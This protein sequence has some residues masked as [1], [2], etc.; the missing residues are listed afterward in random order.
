MTEDLLAEIT[1]IRSV[2]TRLD[3]RIAALETNPQTD[4]TRPPKPPENADPTKLDPNSPTPPTRPAANFTPPTRQEWTLPAPT[5]TPLPSQ[6]APQLTSLAIAKDPRQHPA[7]A[8]LPR[9]REVELRIG[10]IW[11]V[12]IGI[13]VLL[14]GLVFLGNHVYHEFISTLGAAGKLTLVSLAAGLMAGLGHLARRRRSLA[15][16]GRVLTGGAIATG[17]Y[18]AYAAHFVEPLRV[19]ASP[20]IGGSLLLAA[21]GGILWLADRLRSQATAALTISL[22]FYTGA[23]NP[24]T[25]FSLAA[26]VLLAV[27]GVVLL[28][29][30]HWT[31]LSLVS[32][33]GT[34]GAFA[35]WRLVNTSTLFVVHAPTDAAF[36]TAIAFPVC[37]WLVF[38]AAT[39]L[40]RDHA[41]PSST[42]STFLTVNNALLSGLVAPVIAGTHPDALGWATGSF[43]VILIG[44]AFLSPKTAAGTYLI[45][46]LG[47]LSAGLLL[48]F[49]GSQ[50]ALIFAFQSAT[51]LTLSRGR[52][53]GILQIFSGLAA[54]IAFAVA[55]ERL[56]NDAPHAPLVALAVAA[57]FAANAFVFKLHRRLLSPLTFSY[58]AGA[59]LVLATLLLLV[60]VVQ[61]TTGDIRLALLVT[62]GLATTFTTRLTRLPELGLCGQFVAVAGQLCWFA[63]NPAHFT[64]PLPFGLVLATGLTLIHWWQRQSVLPVDPQLRG[65]AQ[66]LH[67]LVPA[68]VL[69]TWAFHLDGPIPREILLAL[70]GLGLLLY[71]F[72]TRAW[73]IAFATALLVALATRSTFISIL[74]GES[75]LAP[76]IATALICAHSFVLPALARRAPITA[77]R[78][79]GQVCQLVR[80]VALTLAAS[81]VL[82]FVPV[83][84]HAITFAA[85]ALSLFTLAAHPAQREPLIQAT[86][87]AALALGS[88]AFSQRHGGSIFL[89]DLLVFGAAIIAQ[90]LATR[91]PII[92][93]PAQSALI[94]TA[95]TGIWFIS[96]RAVANVADGLLITA[97]WSGLAAAA[98]AL[99]FLWRERTYRHA[100]LGVLLVTL[101][102]LVLV[103]VWQFNTLTRILSF[104]TL[105]IVLVLSG[106]L[107]NALKDHA[108]KAASRED[109]S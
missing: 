23:V 82:T 70:L 5:H 80:A 67:T 9:D 55:G 74:Q 68:A 94:V 30:N 12:R 83:Q 27:V 103:D 54:A 102:R 107:Y 90:R 28:L 91:H 3:R 109:K 45:Q 87:L 61:N 50:R 75:W 85:A 66:V 7:P 22:A 24:V 77:T 49:T 17:Y 26:N 4:A 73:T 78:A 71:G 37:Y 8:E 48:E 15:N 84:W 36:V 35:F 46:G 31:A 41:F 25:H 62:L 72:L 39:L 13:V 59:F 16:F 32:L 95:V 101:S 56:L 18:A 42:R 52:H 108:S 44:L 34:Y 69:C 20:L 21:A 106:F 93:S 97:S 89:P 76:T 64:N 2:H 96:G 98:I 29:R 58:R 57:V 11:L 14:T 81:I 105:G 86:I 100:G 1:S 79:F 63:Q 19:I 92:P 88:F 47:L 65:N 10:R 38:T 99:G 53:G 51:L 40:G 60:T 104:I 43:G 6:P 33:I